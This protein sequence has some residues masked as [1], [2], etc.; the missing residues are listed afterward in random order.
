MRRLLVPSTLL[1]LA[2]VGAP[3]LAAPRA[4]AE[5]VEGLEPLPAS[6]SERPAEALPASSSSISSSSASSPISSEHERLTKRW[7]LVDDTAAITLG[8][9]AFRLQSGGSFQHDAIYGEI[10]PS[11]ALM[12]CEGEGRSYVPS[13]DGLKLA[14]TTLAFAAVG[15]GATWLV[16]APSERRFGVSSIEVKL[17]TGATT[18]LTLIGRF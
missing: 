15:V 8:V 18:G 2:A 16:A 11:C 17:S 13:W 10:R 14:S 1:A 3:L 7:D 4:R 9:A 6:T 12:S 5:V